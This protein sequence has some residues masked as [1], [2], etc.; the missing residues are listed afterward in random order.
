LSLKNPGGVSVIDEKLCI[1]LIVCIWVLMAASNSPYAA[2]GELIYIP[3]FN[4]QYCTTGVTVGLDKLSLYLIVA[5][6]VNYI[7]P[8]VCMWMAYV[9]I[10]QMMRSSNGKVTVNW[11]FQVC[12]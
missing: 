8:M 3:Y 7:I 11:K 12:D 2:W 5:R 9:S 4:I 1:I 10:A 6:S